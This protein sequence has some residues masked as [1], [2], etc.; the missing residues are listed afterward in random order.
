[1]RLLDAEVVQQPA[2]VLRHQPRAV[3]GFVIQL[4]ALAVAAVVQRNYAVSGAR[5]GAQPARIDPVGGHVGGKTVDQ[6]DWQLF[7][8]ARHPDRGLV[9]ERDID[10]T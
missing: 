8:L 4:G 6:Q 2:R 1:V 7:Q 5:K 9:Y 3:G 10:A